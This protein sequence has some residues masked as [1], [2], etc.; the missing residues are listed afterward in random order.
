MV[1]LSDIRFWEASPSFIALLRVSCW[2]SSLVRECSKSWITSSSR[3]ANMMPDF[4]AI[5]TS[6]KVSDLRC[7][8]GET[9]AREK[10]FASAPFD[11][12]STLEQ[13]KRSHLR[14]R[15]LPYVD[16]KTAVIGDRKPLLR[17][18]LAAAERSTVLLKNEKGLLPLHPHAFRR[19]AVIGPMADSKQDL[20]GP[21]LANEDV[22]EVV[23]IRH[24]LEKS[25]NFES[26]TYAQGV[27][28]RRVYP[29][30]FDRKLKEKPQAPWTPAEAD[31]QLQHAVDVAADADLIIAV[32]GETSN[33][34]GESASRSSLDLPGR[35]DELL[36]KVAALGK[37]I[38][39]VLLGGRS[40]TIGWGADPPSYD[41]RRMVSRNRGWRS[42]HRSSLRSSKPERQTRAAGTPSLA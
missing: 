38:V 16:E 11:R 7:G 40:L 3:M 6:G 39:L 31:A 4:L 37:P 9:V 26:V 2:S 5:V 30:P 32:M 28:I 1:G 36:K 41:F 19:V 29:S 15:P 20:L 12:W 21:W 22:D 24:A 25:N 34:T 42:H 17:A 10:L 8:L 13:V 14:I 23:S 18:A 33:M 35:Q 27:Q